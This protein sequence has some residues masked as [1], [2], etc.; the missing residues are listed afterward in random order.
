MKILLLLLLLF[1]YTAF[2]SP[3]AN[4]QTPDAS[5]DEVILKGKVTEI[6]KNQKES[7]YKREHLLQTLTIELET[8]RKVEIQ[9]PRFLLTKNGGYHVGDPV[10]VGEITDSTQDTYHYL[11]GYDRTVPLTILFAIFLVTALLVTR[12]VGI[13][14]LLGMGFSLVVI[15]VFILPSIAKGHNPIIISILGILVIIP[16]SFYLSHGFTKKTHVAC[17]SGLI[18]LIATTLLAKIFIDMTNLS[19]LEIADLEALLFV[20]NASFDASSLLIAGIVI[21]TFG[22]LDDVTISQSSLVQE[23]AKASKK[24]SRKSLYLHATKVGNDH[25]ASV[26]NTLILV[27]VGASLPFLLLFTEFPKPLNVTISNESITLAIVTALVSTIGLI[28]AVP[29]TTAIAS[30]VFAGNKSKS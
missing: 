23:L 25:I 15:F 4:A 11:I 2:F 8:G 9:T 7:V 10:F 6:V 5:G 18:A 26:I 21:S 13:R 30:I 17:L 22:I 24:L 1:L 20:K 3:T 28:I 16:V 29:I 14:S 19:G 27:Y 12:K